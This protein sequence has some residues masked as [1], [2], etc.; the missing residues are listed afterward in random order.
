[1]YIPHQKHINSCDLFPPTSY[2]VLHPAFHC[3]KHCSRS[4]S[5]HLMERWVWFTLYQKLVFLNVTTWFEK[6]SKMN[7]LP[8]L[9]AI[10]NGQFTLLNYYYRWM[11]YCILSHTHCILI[12]YGLL[13][14][15]PSFQPLSRGQID[16][17]EFSRD[18]IWFFAPVCVRLAEIWP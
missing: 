16:I 2:A 1:M 17:S 3:C 13:S 5:T 8:P 18:D 15:P 9:K 7:S 14:V 12:F 10:C 4:D 6:E 11:L